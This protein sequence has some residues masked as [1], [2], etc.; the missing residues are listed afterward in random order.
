MNTKPAKVTGI[1]AII[2]G[3][4]FILAGGVTWGLITSNLNEQNIT[5]ADDSPMLA[6]DSVNGPFSAFAQAQII[7]THAEAATNGKTYAE[8]GGEVAAAQESGDTALAEELQTQ[9][10]TMMNASFLRASLFTSVVAY[11]VAAL[12]MGLGV[13]LILVGWAFSSLGR[14]TPAATTQSASTV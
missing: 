6:G 3:I 2:A 8:L 11:G 1:I 10:T 13:V 7:N 9:R 5:V 14:T 12:V 4:I